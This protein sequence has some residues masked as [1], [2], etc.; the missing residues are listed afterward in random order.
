MCY[1]TS[2]LGASQ[3]IVRVTLDDIQGE[4]EEEDEEGDDAVH[5]EKIAEEMEQFKRRVELEMAALRNATTRVLMASSG[6]EEE[7]DNRER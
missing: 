1:A 4:K 2:R 6:N 5:S 7:E 3:D